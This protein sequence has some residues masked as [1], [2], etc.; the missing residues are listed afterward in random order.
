MLNSTEKL[1]CLISL[2]LGLYITHLDE[3]KTIAKL[4]EE[5][6]FLID[7]HYREKVAQD[8]QIQELE[9]KYNLRPTT[10]PVRSGARPRCS[11]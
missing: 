1:D 3:R 11:S 9:R 10:K 6:D 2:I 7:E 5:I 4:V 8:P